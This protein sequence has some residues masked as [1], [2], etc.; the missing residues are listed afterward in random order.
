MLN[1]KPTVAK[2]R[3]FTVSARWACFPPDMEELE[4]ADTLENVVSEDFTKSQEDPESLLTS[5]S[6]SPGNKAGRGAGLMA[7][8]DGL[9]AS[10]SG[11]SAG[12]LL[13]ATSIVWLDTVVESQR[14]SLW[15]TWY[16]TSPATEAEGVR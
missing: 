16:S 4:K 9:T 13:S 14:A 15:I 5:S 12:L 1:S 2:T 10:E 8:G 7:S 3:A 6:G 11:R